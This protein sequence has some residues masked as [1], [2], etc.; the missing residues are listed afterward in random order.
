MYTRIVVVDKDINRY[1]S[2]QLKHATSQGLNFPVY[3]FTCPSGADTFH[4]QTV[5]A[6]VLLAKAR[7]A[8][9]VLSVIIPPHRVS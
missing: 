4:A 1:T 7:R 3:H 8:I 2:K 5:K 9:V 6:W